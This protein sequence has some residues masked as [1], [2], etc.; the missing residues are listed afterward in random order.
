MVGDD[1]AEHRVTEQLE[2]LVGRQPAPLGAVGAVGQR[3]AQQVGIDG[4]P[5]ER[6][7][8]PSA[9]GPRLAGGIAQA[10]STFA[11]T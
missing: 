4:V 11:L 1:E 3:L 9:L 5:A 8:Q 6:L 7:A 10:A 2:P